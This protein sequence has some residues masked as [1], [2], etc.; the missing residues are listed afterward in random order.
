MRF[1]WTPAVTRAFQDAQI[2]ARRLG[3]VAV[4]PAHLLH[5][6]LVEAEGRAAALLAAAGLDP[7]RASRALA[8]HPPSGPAHPAETALPFSPPARAALEEARRLTGDLEAAD[9]TV[10]SEALLLAL[11]RSDEP[12]RRSLESLGLDFARLE[13]GFRAAHRPALE[14]DEP[15]CLAETIEE[16]DTARI[17]DAAANRAREALRVVEDYCRFALDDAFLSGELKQLRHDLVGMLGALGL[18]PQQSLAARETLRDVGTG[19]STVGEGQRDSLL[20]VVR[21]NL[22]R[23]QEALRSLEEFGKLHGPERGQA[24][25]RLRYRSYTLER[26]ILLGTDARQRLAEARLYVLLTGSQC[27]TALDWTIQE[28]A[29]GGAQVFQLR[30]KELEDRALLERARQVR[31]WTRRAGA[32]FLVNDRPDIAR[33]AEADGVHLGQDDMP[34]KDAR[35]ILGPDA[36]IGVSTHDIAQVRQAVLDGASYIGVGPT[37]P[38]GTKTFAEFPGLGFVRQALA[39]TSLPAFVIGGVSLDTVGAAVAT[40]ARRV[41]VSAA[42]GRADEPR[43]V[44]MLLRQALAG[45]PLTQ[46]G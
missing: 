46:P 21:A 9:Q 17:L 43:Q 23:L 33:L 8:E 36:L 11:L 2:Q 22:K 34:V 38:S 6:L 40:G 24:V 18:D 45:A 19:L 29:A 37:F 5:G 13:G 16:I 28:A 12:L 14:L 20:S 44:A 32:L 26:A 10:P 39:E 27:T 3:A 35:R 7:A 42:I 4:E 30:E 31:R 25:E 41:A 15:L 1:E